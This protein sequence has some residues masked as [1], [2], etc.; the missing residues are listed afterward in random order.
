MTVLTFS[1]W[2]YKEPRLT[3]TSQHSSANKQLMSCL[4]FPQAESEMISRELLE[5]IGVAVRE[6]QVGTEDKRYHPLQ[7]I[8]VKAQAMKRGSRH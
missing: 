7:F 2:W 6:K 1:P 3:K 4:V 8:P 5:F